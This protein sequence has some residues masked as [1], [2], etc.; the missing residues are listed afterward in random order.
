MVYYKQTAINKD[1]GPI[2]LR[3]NCSKVYVFN[4]FCIFMIN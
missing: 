4:S 1:E 3:E 2:G